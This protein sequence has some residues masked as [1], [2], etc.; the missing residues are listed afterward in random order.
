M[1]SPGAAARGGFAGRPG[2]ASRPRRVGHL[3]PD[4][5]RTAG[6][7]RRGAP[8]RRLSRGLARGGLAPR[9]DRCRIRAVGRAGAPRPPAPLR[10]AVAGFGAARRQPRP[11][12]QRRPRRRRAAD[13]SR[14]WA[15]RLHAAP[16]EFGRGARRLCDLHGRRQHGA[17]L[18]A[19]LAAPRQPVQAADPRP[20]RRRLQDRPGGADQA[21][22]RLAG[23]PACPA[24]AQPRRDAPHRPR[25]GGRMPPDRR[26]G[27]GGISPLR[28]PQRIFPTERAPAMRTTYAVNDM[29]IHRIVEQEHGFTPML[30]FLPNLTKE[31]LEENLSWLAPGGYD[32]KTGNV[33]LCFQSYVVKT[34]H[35]NILVDSCI[36]NDKNFPLRPA[37]NKK[38]DGNW[39][40][41]LKAANLAPGDIDFVMCTHLHGDHVGWNTKLEN[42][43][44]VPTFPKARYLFSKKEYAYWSEIHQKTPLDQITDS[45][46]PII[47]AN[48][49]ELVTSD[50]SLNDHIRLSPTPGH[51]PDHFAVCAGKGGDA[52]VFT[53]DLIHSPIQARYPELV[54]RVDT[55]RDQGVRTRRNFLERYCDTGT[56]CC[57]MHFPSPSVG[58]IKRW[59][60]GFRLEYAKA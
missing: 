51:T 6:K 7:G 16:V 56:L 2:P 21:V 24:P 14:G 26:R 20:R 41:A 22:R 43:R 55:D 27:S 23:R 54:M 29:T 32:P 42:G 50:H 15:D 58:H 13:V 9:R 40:A 18:R 49:A 46:L 30:E 48:R 19:G 37:W 45:V 52:A 33:V 59:G 3:A 31:R 4:Q 1:A 57:T 25:G 44:W 11:D 53:G 47:E 39:M 17:A 60:D 34:P 12:P 8:H 38:Q 10:R 35:H 36:G 5:R 28:S